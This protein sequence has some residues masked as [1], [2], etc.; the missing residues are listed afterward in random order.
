[1][2]DKQNDD[3]F[4]RATALR[5]RAEQ[6]LRARPADRPTLPTQDVQALVQELN[7]YQ[8][9]LEIQNE[10][11]RQAQVELAHTRD[12]YADLYEFAPVGYVT[13]NK[14]G[15]IVEANLTAAA[16]LGVE[17]HAL[18]AK[19]LA[20]FADRASQDACYLHLQ[21]VSSSETKQTC[22]V[23]M[24][25]ADGTPV[26]VRLESIAFAA[27]HERRCRMALVDI[28][29]ARRV[30]RQLEESEQRYRR[31]TEAVT[32][33]IYRVRVEHGRAAETIHGANCEA[34]TGYTPRE[35]AA[36][37]LLWI[38]MVPPEDRLVVEQRA[39]RILSG[40]DAPPIEHRICRKDGAMRW[41]LN[42]TSSQHD[43]RGRLIAYD[44]LLRDITDRKEAE[45]ALNRLNAELD[46]RVGQRTHEI[47]LLAEAISHLGEGV[48]ITD[49]DLDWPGPN[50]LFVNEALC[51]ITGYTFDELLG[52]TPRVLQGDQTSR[53]ATEQMRRELA[54]NRSCVIE[55]VNYRKDGTPY[56]A[57][58]FITP[59]W[60]AAGH[61]TNFVS[62]HRD[63]SER[64]RAARALR[65]SEEQ[66]RAI[67]D[68]ATDAIITI[69]ERGIVTHANPATEC[70]FGYARD[71]L[72]GR[73]VNM[74]MPRP[75]HDEHDGYISR[76]LRTGEARIIGIG[77][78]VTA[79]R[80]DGSTFPADLAVSR[81]DHMGLFTGVIRDV[82]F[83]KELERQVLEI[84][85]AEQRRIG[86][87]LHDG[88]G[89]ELTGLA[90]FAGTLAELLDRAPKKAIDQSGHWLVDEAALAR[91]RLTAGRLSAGLGEA[92][93]HVQQLS[94]G[95]L[96]VQV[97]AEGLRSALEELAAKTDAQQTV[98]CRFE[99]PAVV[100]VF[101][102]TTATYLYR[103][104]QEAVNNA[105][106][107]SRA[108]RIAI[109]LKQAKDEIV[110]DV[111]DNGVGF[112]SVSVGR[113]NLSRTTHGFGL[114]IMNYRAGM[115]GGTLRIMRRPE[116]GTSITCTVPLPR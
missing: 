67:L 52:Q 40:E 12:R 66:M 50:I 16:M 26:A 43:D 96:P 84:S 21:A 53:E 2:H 105:L 78:E 11:L 39:T 41:V 64:K 45:T 36:N 5:H 94:H 28:T 1:M 68:T 54:E 4:Q 55:L 109:S 17:R 82:S 46:R 27:E 110:L 29:D 14:D 20:S 30:R 87:E 79:L 51:R 89:Q 56:D 37:P 106:R 35:F 73:N 23:E 103:I 57:E 62:I 49:D 75:Y 102:N 93:R 115:I 114:E 61:R 107:H 90:L 69:D 101:N 7:V 32:D 95:I 70:M 44:G 88:T 85:V 15:K 72:V 10:E 71:D 77:R 22:D 42:T 63:I 58:L 9:E 13:L 83:R 48:M 108:D 98:A 60:D 99:C 80:K 86:Q 65:D 19:N 97:A 91:L 3:G 112:D 47:S 24:H 33:Y 25:K 92:N 38:A 18:L 34:V 6:L 100:T 113:R 8:M 81:V 59:L 74:L 31:L 76:Y 111:S 104:A 116:G